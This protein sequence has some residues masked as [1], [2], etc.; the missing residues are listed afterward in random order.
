MRIPYRYRP[1]GGFIF[2]V[3]V[4]AGLIAFGTWGFNEPPLDRAWRLLE[5][6]DHGLVL[7]DDDRG[8]LDEA[9]R[10]YPG[11]TADI[12]DDE[13]VDLLEPDVNGFSAATTT[14]LLLAPIGPQGRRFELSCRGAASYPLTLTVE[15]PKLTRGLVFKGDGQQILTL[16]PEH[17]NAGPHAPFLLKLQ[18]S[19]GFATPEKP[20]APEVGLRVRAAQTLRPTRA[21]D[22]E[23]K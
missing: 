21:S 13:A 6:V 11:I 12:L 5:G 9:L 18:L 14:H 16:G 19:G 3:L 8:F 17:A 20:G 2:L 4:L 22:G 1:G 7:T 23:V 10:R 15:G